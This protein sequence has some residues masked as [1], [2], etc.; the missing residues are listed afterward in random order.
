MSRANRFLCLLCLLCINTAVAETDIETSAIF[1]HYE[2]HY[3][4]LPTSFLQPDIAKAYGIVRAEN[5][6]L[7]TIAV[8]DRDHPNAGGLPATISGSRTDL[9]QRHALAF[10]T[11]QEQTATYFISEFRFSGRER[12][13]F[14]INI[15][16]EGSN[17]ALPLHFEKTFELPE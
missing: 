1:G 15:T 10:Q 3:S 11:V 14:D 7:I 6:A 17:T 2:V 16:P 5:R 4:V 13:I 9:I 8:T 12:W